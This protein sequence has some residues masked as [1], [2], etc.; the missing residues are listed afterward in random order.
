MSEENNLTELEKKSKELKNVDEE[1]DYD[2]GQDEKTA[3]ERTKW[4]VLLIVV[5]IVFV[6]T[7]FTLDKDIPFK[8]PIEIAPL[9]FVS[10]FLIAFK[11]RSINIKYGINDGYFTPRYDTPE[12]L[13]NLQHSKHA[14]STFG[15]CLEDLIKNHILL[16]LP[17]I[18]FYGFALFLMLFFLHFEEDAEEAPSSFTGLVKYL[19]RNNPIYAVLLSIAV[20][21]FP[22]ILIFM[23]SMMIGPLKENAGIGY[24]VL[25]GFIALILTAIATNF[26]SGFFSFV[27][28]IL[29]L[30]VKPIRGLIK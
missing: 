9:L 4:I 14:F 19:F 1:S 23:E 6:Y 3:P 18:F 15:G 29:S 12:Q 22:V 28:L 8:I 10:M 30:I 21:A 13:E 27:A 25:F 11:I 5:L 20:L 7:M 24:Y 17:V 2:K 26:L 16:S